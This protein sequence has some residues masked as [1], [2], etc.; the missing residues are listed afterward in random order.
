MTAKSP[1]SHDNRERRY[2][3]TP[4][5]TRYQKQQKRQKRPIQMNFGHNDQQIAPSPGII[6]DT[7]VD[8]VSHPPPPLYIHAQTDPVQI[9]PNPTI[10]THID[11]LPLPC[12]WAFPVLN[13]PRNMVIYHYPPIGVLYGNFA[14]FYYQKLP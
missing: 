13:Y 7:T 5:M 12:R 3:E 9:T 4:K 2:T 10:V 14:G 6:F 1:L 11:L 8:T